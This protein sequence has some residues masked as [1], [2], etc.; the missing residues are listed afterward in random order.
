ML[1]TD[2]PVQFLRSL[3]ARLERSLTGLSLLMGFGGKSSSDRLG[4]S[5]VVNFTTEP[6]STGRY[7]EAS[8]LIGGI[9]AVI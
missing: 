5:F 8:G 1:M 9:Q 7:L 3:G 4:L 6:K 2:S